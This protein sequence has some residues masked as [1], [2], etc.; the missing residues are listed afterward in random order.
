MPALNTGYIA[1]DGG[2][3]YYEA[4]GQGPPVVLLHPGPGELVLWAPQ[5][6][7]LEPQFRLIRYDARGFGRSDLPTGPFAHFED[8]RML[9]DALELTRVSLVGLS[10]GGRT[11][12][13]F[14]LAYPE[15]VDRL[16]L[17]NAGVSGFEVKGFERYDRDYEEAKAAGDLDGM[18]EVI[19]SV[20]VDGPRR[21][22][23]EVV[24]DLRQRY[25]RLWIDH[26]RRRG[27]TEWA[28][29]PLTPPAL[30]RLGEVRAPT[31]V[32]LAELD[33]PSIAEQAHLLERNVPG[34]QLVVIQGAA[35]F[36]N[37]E[38]PLEFNVVINEFLSQ[39]GGA[40]E[41][42]QALGDSGAQA[43]TKP[44]VEQGTERRPYHPMMP[45]ERAERLRIWQEQAYAGG[46]RDGPLSVEH[47]GFLIVVP[48]DVYPPNPL[49]LAEIVL[50]EVQTR[51]RVL[52][53]GTGSG[54]NALA[55]A[56]KAS[57]VVAV[58]IS[59]SAVVCARDNAARNGLSERIEVRESDLFATVVGRFD[60]IMFDPPFRWFRPRDMRER[61]TADENYETL[62]SFFERVP[63]YLLPGGRILL[64]FGTSGDI[65]YLRH[66]MS[67]SGM[68]A[69][70]LRK[71]EGVKDDLPV[72]YFVYRLASK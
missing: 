43:L 23:S 31:L 7:A 57:E 63:G 28:S 2:R 19:A 69:E 68:A 20:W 53:V 44:A 67:K 3:L 65:E 24:S 58:D 22:P 47:L 62:T 5:L 36:V 16:V 60:L 21:T 72:A 55:A 15:R 11:A 45:V 14:A 8:L 27:N 34:S 18:A 54:I 38:R 39:L 30:E 71:V 51:D 13:D 56:T 1:I 37:L 6:P 35:H 50:R 4:S 32:V 26:H 61:A 49:G 10:L 40:N 42:L 41:T 70:E 46:R 59:P 48:P 25:K 9:L 17:A 33:Q 29:K 12:L 66:L 64:S 52:D